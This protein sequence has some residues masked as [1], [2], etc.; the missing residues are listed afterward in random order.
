[1]KKKTFKEKVAFYLRIR[2]RAFQRRPFVFLRYLF[3][4][5]FFRSLGIIICLFFTVIPLPLN[6]LLQNMFSLNLSFNS[7]K[8]VVSSVRKMAFNFNHILPSVNDI[9]RIMNTFITNINPYNLINILRDIPMDLRQFMLKFFDYLRERFKDLRIFIRS[10]WPPQNSWRKLRL[11]IR[12]HT[13]I[14]KRIIRNILMMVFSLLFTKILFFMIIPLLGIGA[15]YVIGFNVSLIIIGIL[16]LISSQLG[17]LIGKLVNQSLIKLYD[18]LQKRQPQYA[19]R[20]LL[21]IVA[22]AYN[23]LKD[24][25]IVIRQIIC[26]SIVIYIRI[27]KLTLFLSYIY[28]KNYFSGITSHKTIIK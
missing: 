23:Y 17:A 4:I 21:I 20:L 3:I 16:S 24:V 13:I 22:I 27:I 18:Y 1:M 14:L 6:H 7:F 8:E 28:Y 19:M 10:L 26:Q 15:V 11:F 12:V 25:L 9:L 5:L 2:W